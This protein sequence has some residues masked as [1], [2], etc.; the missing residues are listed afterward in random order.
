VNT[1]QEKDLV[2]ILSE[3]QGLC[4][5][6]PREGSSKY[7]VRDTS[8]VHIALVS[9][10]VYL[11]DPSLGQ[12]SHSPCVSDS[13]LTRSFSC[14][15]YV[16]TAQEKDL[17]SILSETQGLCEHCPREGSSKYTVRDTRAM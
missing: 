2:S 16:N 11:L 10:I 1:G 14:K 9:L 15:G 7:T 13:I 4:E 17:V 3:T 8:S 6:C 5:H 12:C